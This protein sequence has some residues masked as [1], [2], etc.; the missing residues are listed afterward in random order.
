MKTLVVDHHL[1]DCDSWFDT[2]KANPPP[3]YGQWR[4]VRGTDNP[5]RVLVIGLIDDSEVNAVQEHLDS[6]QMQKVFAVVND[7]ST[8]PV[9]FIWFDDVTPG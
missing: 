9:E 1:K 7:G 5:N 6:D 8:Q 3:A 2:F 4:V